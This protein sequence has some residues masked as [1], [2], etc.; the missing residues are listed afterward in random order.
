MAASCSA[1]CV[2]AA[3]LPQ[4]ARSRGHRRLAVGENKKFSNPLDDVGIF[5]AALRYRLFHLHSHAD[6]RKGGAT[7]AFSV[8]Q[9]YATDMGS[10]RTSLTVAT[11]DDFY[12]YARCPKIVSIRSYLA[13]HETP[14]PRPSAP[15][16]EPEIESHVLGK[17]GEAA[18][19]EAFS[20]DWFE[21]EDSADIAAFGK[22]VAFSVRRQLRR[23]LTR[24]VSRLISDVGENVRQIKT[25]LR[26]IYPSIRLVGRG[27]C[28]LGLLPTEGRPDFVA[29]TTGGRQVLIEV[30]TTGRPN[31]KDRFQ[32]EW[33]NHMARRGTLTIVENR[34]ERYRASLAPMV[35]RS[36]ETEIVIAYPRLGSFERVTTAVALTRDSYRLVWEAKQLGFRKRWPPTPCGLDCPHHD[37][38]IALKEDSLDPIPP[39]ATIFGDGYLNLDGD[40]NQAYWNSYLDRAIGGQLARLRREE[41]FA[42]QREAP[43]MRADFRRLM[44]ESGF[45][46]EATWRALRST[47]RPWNSK[48]RKSVTAELRPWK[49]LLGRAFDGASSHAIGRV[50][51]VYALPKGSPAF[52]RGSLEKF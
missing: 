11:R 51:R 2:V 43:T 50:E 49:R 13:V 21:D 48:I 4:A 16:A 41:A 26:E 19:E 34:Q 14:K 18:V 37:Y 32:A 46:S 3:L 10:R 25:Q 28:R 24:A 45:P 12:H 52:V 23:P 5:S 29:L 7:E 15:R 17:V 39:L 35:V 33:Y 44:D 40:L 20:G 8:L 1:V 42:K 9:P 6:Q 31:A 27:E 36:A 30:K 38:G 47:E 22:R